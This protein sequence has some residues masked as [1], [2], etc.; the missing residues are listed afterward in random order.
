MEQNTAINP[1]SDS[2]VSK[3]TAQ[4]NS[5]S[6]HDVLPTD[7]VLASLMFSHD[8]HNDSSDMENNQLSQNYAP[9]KDHEKRAKIPPQ[10][11]STITHNQSLVDYEDS[12]L[13]D[14]A[15]ESAA[16]IT[17]SESNSAE[18]KF[19]PTPPVNVSVPRKNTEFRERVSSSESASE[20]ESDS[21][22]SF[23]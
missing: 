16:S 9:I 2:V 8:I 19:K 22:T 21:S 17:D 6:L 23:R 11:S 20:Y 7:N 12:D 14:S 10:D 5:N 13:E 15:S 18:T 1:I 4:L 3:N